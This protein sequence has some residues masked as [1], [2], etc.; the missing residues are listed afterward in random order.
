M[1]GRRRKQLFALLLAVGLCLGEVS[2]FYP[3][4]MPVEAA[5][6]EE[7]SFSDM[8]APGT[9]NTWL[10]CGGTEGV[11]DFATEGTARNWA[12]LFEDMLRYYG[13]FV[14]RG[15]FVF[16]TSRRGADIGYILEHYDTMIAPYGTLAVGIMAGEADY[17]KG[18]AGEYNFIRDLEALA[19]QIRED[20][21]LPFFITPYPPADN[22]QSDMAE[23][24]KEAVFEAAGDEV[25]VVD[26][27]G[28]PSEM[29]NEDNSLTPR[30]HQ[31]VANQIKT[32]L[33]VRDTNNQIPVTNYA[34]NLL[35]DGDYTVAKKAPD[36]SLALIKDVKAQK[37]AITV[38]VDVSSIHTDLIQLA[39]SLADEKGQTISALAK[40]GALSFTIDG[41]KPEE[42]YTL[43]VY[44]TGSGNVTEAYCPVS[45][46]ASTDGEAALCEFPDENRFVNEKIRALF[47]GN[48]PATYLFM[49]D[50]ITHGI[51]T[52]GYDNV[53]QMFAKYLDE[54]GR[55]DDVVLNTGVSN[56]TIATT[57]DQIE[58]RLTR[59]NPDVVMVM[60]GTNDVSYRGEN[61][62]NNGTASMGAITV[63][64]FK[65]RY[66]ELVRK[67]HENNADTSIVLRIPCEMLVDEPHSGY[68]EKFNAIYD[69]A[70]EMQAE[71]PDLNIVVINHR[72]EWLDYSSNVRN[73][74]ISKTGTYGWLVDNVHP[75][76]RGNLS[77]FQQIIKELGLYVNTSKLANYQYA[78]DEWS[79]AS[80]IEAPVIQRGTRAQFSMDALAGYTAGI[81][82]V[83]LT[84]SEG[85]REISHT[86]T[87]TREG[88]LTLDG[89]DPAK[90]YVAAVTGKDAVTSK[91]IS[92]AA[93]LTKSADETATES[94]RQ[95][96]AGSLAD[97]KKE[98]T[99]AY[100]PEVLAA[101]QA[102]IKAVEEGYTAKPDLT[103][104]E[105]DT[106]LIALKTARADAK[107]A[108]EAAKNEAVSQLMA[109][110]ARADAIYEAG[111]QN[112]TTESWNAYV[113]AYQAV[114]SANA[115]T[116]SVVDLRAL[117]L[118]L[119]EAESSLKALPGQPSDPAPTPHSDVE[120]GKVYTVGNYHYKVTDAVQLTAEVIG[121]KNR[122]ITKIN[123]GNNVAINGV[124]LKITSIAPS[125]FKNNKKAT[126]AVIGGSVEIIG[127]GAFSGCAKLKTANIKS[128][129]LKSI[130]SKAFYN[131]KNLKK[132]VLKTKILKKAGK[133]A[134]KGTY[135]KLEIKVPK[136]KYKDY[137][138]LLKKK[139]QGK[140]AKIIK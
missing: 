56:A 18:F 14:E 6:R 50:S 2:P 137:K 122:G 61:N 26:L 70:D 71:I 46:T 117:I 81:K 45:I 94:E 106:A 116:S 25:P 89:L 72:Q 12:G 43:T 17:S 27:F 135:K 100:P 130:G 47:T 139:G 77:M 20:G 132:I 140:K 118:A 127:N 30:G 1:K 54:M 59:Y 119:Y 82:E 83:T 103:V 9:C 93:L 36:G 10:F 128:T 134:F 51:V 55:E 131:C 60:L 39:Y 86:A 57:L 105:L 28:L 108:F 124:S 16:N 3:A 68:E 22:S 110:V 48:K 76:G 52:Q 84:L 102:A 21:K 138:N 42:T 98:D 111:K 79:A 31:E 23:V 13:T 112:Y 35:S 74:N 136:A 99:S 125:A 107:R 5:E 11:A 64:Q 32:T 78:L 126:S 7:T 15:R 40:K 34:F 114:K 101:Y 92:F 62:V 8:W 95:E 58:P 97:A 90:T 123:I 115:D 44:D 41:L 120:K 29:I 66:K 73:D 19:S 121:T 4:L 88:M 113:A 129:E 104:T 33:S 85:G 65:S 87:Y 109:A 63:E 69:V 75:N 80:D 91:T 24:Y 37:G 96:L 53:P 49:G 133:Y 38:S 67:I